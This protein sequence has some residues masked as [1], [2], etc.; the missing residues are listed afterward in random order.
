MMTATQAA[1]EAAQMQR[2]QQ[3]RGQLAERRVRKT[4]VECHAGAMERWWFREATASGRFGESPRRLAR[5]GRRAPN[6]TLNAAGCACRTS[7]GAL[8]FA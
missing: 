2:K 3:Q 8:F 4:G 6:A 7:A 1:R 5:D